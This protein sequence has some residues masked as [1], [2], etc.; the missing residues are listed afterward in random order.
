[1]VLGGRELAIYKWDGD[2]QELLR[3]VREKLNALGEVK[4]HFYSFLLMP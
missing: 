1:M 4:L 3:G 2:E